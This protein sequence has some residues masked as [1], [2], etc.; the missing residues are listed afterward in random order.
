MKNLALLR[1][2]FICRLC[3]PDLVPESNS[4]KKQKN[5]KE[6]TENSKEKSKMDKAS[7]KKLPATKAWHDTP[8]ILNELDVHNDIVFSVDI[9]EDYIISGRYC[10]FYF[11]I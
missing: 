2:V 11:V 7:N 6:E 4:N 5:S 10:S 3:A 8:F 9:D 1:H